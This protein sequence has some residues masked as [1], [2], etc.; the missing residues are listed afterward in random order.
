MLLVS[1]VPEEGINALEI[2]EI[3][4]ADSTFQRHIEQNSASHGIIDVSFNNDG[5]SYLACGSYMSD[6]GSPYSFI[7]LYTDYDH[8]A[9]QVDILTSFSDEEQIYK[10]TFDSYDNVWAFTYA[11]DDEDNGY[12]TILEYTFDGIF[13]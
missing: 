7:K 11:E 3:C 9:W 2:G 10:C 8:L 1:I 4:P 12:F 13:V 6:G 5:L